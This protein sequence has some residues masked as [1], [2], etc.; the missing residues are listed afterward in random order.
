MRSFVVAS[1]SGPTLSVGTSRL[2]VH[3]PSCTRYSNVHLQL[4]RCPG[5]L[6]SGALATEGSLGAG[7]WYVLLPSGVE[8]PVS[9]VD[10]GVPNHHLTLTPGAVPVGAAGDTFRLSG[11]R[12]HGSTAGGGP[13]PVPV[14][15]T[16]LGACWLRIP[17][18]IRGVNV[19]GGSAT[20][21]AAARCGALK[22]GRRLWGGSGRRLGWPCYRPPPPAGGPALPYTGVIANPSAYGVGCGW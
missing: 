13:R 11:T 6:T 2:D 20:T 9:Y 8:E 5:C 16:R 10:H 21:F 18:F 4:G 3:S 19:H 1:R 14:L 17:G 15:T 7:L 22:P 12:H